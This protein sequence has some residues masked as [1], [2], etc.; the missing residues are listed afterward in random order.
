MTAVLIWRELEGD[1]HTRVYDWPIPHHFVIFSPI[2][3]NETIDP[4]R[5]QAAIVEALAG[6]WV[7]VTGALLYVRSVPG[8]LMTSLGFV[9]AGDLLEVLEARTLSGWGYPWGRIGEIKR[10]GSLSSQAAAVP[11]LGQPGHRWVYL[12]YVESV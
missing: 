5:L 2:R 12:H 10:N 8:N 1:W 9:K 4:V 3:S 6:E 7:R 11:G